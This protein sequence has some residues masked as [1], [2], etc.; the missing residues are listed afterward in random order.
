MGAPALT[1]AEY[2]KHKKVFEIHAL[3]GFTPALG[4][5]SETSPLNLGTNR[6]SLRLG[7][8]MVLPFAASAGSTHLELVPS[9]Y[10]SV[11]TSH[12][13]LLLK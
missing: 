4:D 13:N 7:L 3:L 11:T 9:V 6:W 5:Y 12:I 2:V 8:P 10:F 1:P